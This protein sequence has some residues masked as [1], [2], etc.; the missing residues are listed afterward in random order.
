MIAKSDEVEVVG[1]Y[2]YFPAD[3]VDNHYLQ[4]SDRRSV[5]PWKGTA[6]YYDV[7]VDGAVNPRRRGTTPSPAGGRRRSS[8]GA[9]PSGAE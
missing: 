4:P 6:R 8:V 1:G 7:V 3:A 2:S 5:C 9:S